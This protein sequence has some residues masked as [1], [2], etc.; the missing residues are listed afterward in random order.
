[1]AWP[2]EHN[3]IDYFT[4]VYSIYFFKQ[5]K[6]YI[7][8]ILKNRAA[9]FTFAPQ[10]SISPILQSKFSVTILRHNFGSG[11]LSLFLLS[12]YLSGRQGR[13]GHPLYLTKCNNLSINHKKYIGL[14]KHDLRVPEFFSWFDIVHLFLF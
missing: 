8:I 12:I 2:L 10:I 9:F 3:Q 7:F 14:K 1:M 6:K 13:H 5:L 11:S 4:S